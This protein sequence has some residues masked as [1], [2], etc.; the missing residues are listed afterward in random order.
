MGMEA[1][2]W[3]FPMVRTSYHTYAIVKLVLRYMHT[4]MYIFWNLYSL[5]N[6]G[7]NIIYIS[8]TLVFKLT[9]TKTP[10]IW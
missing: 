5:P 3:T 10:A 9:T 7:K 1:N 6:L 2:I 4:H 8:R